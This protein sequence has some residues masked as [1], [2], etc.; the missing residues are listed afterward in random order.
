MK[1]LIVEDSAFIA[2][3]ISLILRKE[4]ISSLITDDGAK[5]PGIV[6]KEKISLVILDIMMPNVSGIEVFEMLKKDPQ[7]SPV[8]ILILTAKTDIL[9]WNDKL[10]F[11]DAFMTKPFDNEELAKEVKRLLCS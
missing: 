4:G 11:C 7:T 10:K 8:K 2:K 1:V 5:V 3:A 6:K 9:K